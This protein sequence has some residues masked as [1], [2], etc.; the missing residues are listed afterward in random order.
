MN[1]PKEKG[2]DGE[3]KITDAPISNSDCEFDIFT[4]YVPRK[5]SVVIKTI[6]PINVDPFNALIF[7]GTYVPPP[8]G[9]QIDT[10]LGTIVM[11][12]EDCCSSFAKSLDP[13]FVPMFQ[14]EVNEGGSESSMSLAIYEKK[15]QRNMCYPKELDPSRSPLPGSLSVSSVTKPSLKK[16]GIPVTKALLEW[17]TYMGTGN[18][19]IQETINL[20][21]TRDAFGR[22][23]YGQCLMSQDG[24]DSVEDAMHKMGDLLQHLY[25]AKLNGSDI[26]R[27]RSIVPV[28]L[29]L[30]DAIDEH[31]PKEK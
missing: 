22:K 28:L 30:I 24:R 4:S 17:L 26:S 19:G 10:E 5:G 14:V 2:E 18:Q 8:H 6:K 25:K 15:T 20:V 9:I 3:H 23:K 1:S 27:I 7:L 29:R 21:S 11:D 31:S 16:Q 13:N 12:H